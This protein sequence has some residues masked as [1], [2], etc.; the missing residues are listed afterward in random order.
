M[1]RDA[2]AYLWDMREA[3]DAI[4]TF[5]AGVDLKAYEA[6]PPYPLGSRAKV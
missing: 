6:N 4:Q 1:R 2:R 3:A 5:I